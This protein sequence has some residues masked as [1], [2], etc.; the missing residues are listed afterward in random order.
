M[1]IRVLA[2][3]RGNR[4]KSVGSVKMAREDVIRINPGD[5]VPEFE[6]EFVGMDAPLTD[7]EIPA[8]ISINRGRQVWEARQKL[9]GFISNTKDAARDIARIAWLDNMIRTQGK[10]MESRYP[11]KDAITGE[12]FDAGAEIYWLRGHGAVIV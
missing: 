1:A 4:I 6:F 12:E 5:Q 9:S 2:R 11:G 7:Q 3:V 8:E 10:R